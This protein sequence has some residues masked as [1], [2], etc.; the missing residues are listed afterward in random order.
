MSEKILVTIR[1]SGETK[2]EVSGVKGEGCK[3]LTASLEKA[4]GEVQTDVSTPEMYEP[5]QHQTENQY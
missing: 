3:S 2:I 1:P 5:E 4:L